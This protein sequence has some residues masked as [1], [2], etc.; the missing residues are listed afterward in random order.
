MALWLR[1]GTNPWNSVPTVCQYT[2]CVH[3]AL[4]AQGIDLSKM[5]M[6]G[7]W[8]REMGGF[9]DVDDVVI[10]IPVGEWLEDEFQR[11]LGAMSRDNVLNAFIAVHPLWH[12]LGK[13][14]EEIDKMYSAACREVIEKNLELFERLFYVFARRTEDD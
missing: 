9:T 1:D 2:D 11:E 3:R 4:L 10:S 12:R 8:L 13:S 6:V 14:Q 5:S 7:E